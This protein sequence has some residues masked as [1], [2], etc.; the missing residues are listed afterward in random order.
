MRAEAQRDAEFVLSLC[1]AWDVRCVC[2]DADVKGIAAREGRSLEEAGRLARYGVFRQVLEESSASGGCVAVAHHQ[3]DQAETLLLSMFRGAG[4]HGLGGIRPVRSMGGDVRLVRPLLF[5]ARGEIEEYLRGAGIDWRTDSSN[6]ETGFSRNKIRNVILPYAAAEVNGAAVEHLARE[7]RLLAETSDFV[8]RQAEAA[9]SRCA[10]R[11]DGAFFFSTAEFL[12]EDPFLQNQMLVECVRAL[13]G[14][15]NFTSAHM[16]E[17]KKLFSEKCQSGRRVE[18]AACHV[19]ACRR[20]SQVVVRFY[21]GGRGECV[22]GEGGGAFATSKPDA[23]GQASAGPNAEEGAFVPLPDEG[24]VLVEGLGE[25][26]VNLFRPA[27]RDGLDAAG[28][29]R[30]DHGPEDRFLERIPRGTYT[31]WFDYDKIQ[32][33]CGF[34]NRRQ[35]DYL[36]IDAVGSRK[37]LKRYLMEEKVPLEQRAGLQVLADGDHVMWVPGHRISTAYYVTKQTRR[38]L[39]VSLFGGVASGG[40]DSEGIRDSEKGR[41]IKEKRISSEKRDPEGGRDGE[42]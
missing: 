36:T 13:G 3:G 40:P 35:G 26:R 32:T 28:M 23:D 37:R 42:N 18:I 12:R 29:S 25:V 33:R 6:L 21:A 31:K 27:E 5:A 15:K 4:L 17:M 41:E 19:A 38:V 11:E 22:G 34:R 30:A 20:F 9:V 1:D 39:Q 2:R 8:R 24:T 10:R 7:A 16:A 14:G